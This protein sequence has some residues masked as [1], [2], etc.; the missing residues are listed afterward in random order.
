[1]L[2]TCEPA[3]VA[4]RPALL[5]VLMRAGLSVVAA[6]GLGVPRRRL[7]ALVR[8]R[9]A[10]RDGPVARRGGARDADVRARVA[11]RLRRPAVPRRRARRRPG[12]RRPRLRSVHQQPRRQPRQ[13]RQ[14][15]A[16]LLATPRRLGA[17]SA[18]AVRPPAAVAPRRACWA[19]S[20]LA[21][22]PRE[23]AR[24]AALRSAMSAA[25]RLGVVRAAAL[26]PG[27]TRPGPPSRARS[28]RPPDSPP[29][30][31]PPRRCSSSRRPHDRLYARL[32]QS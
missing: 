32:F 29:A 1:M 27:C 3:H 14:G 8:V 13:P 18:A 23:L 5:P 16:F 25:V 7:R 26:G 22:N 19:G 31:R 24:C 2:L 9:G 20:R 21:A 11:H 12:R 4:A 15:R 17:A 28:R 30:T 6:R 10:A